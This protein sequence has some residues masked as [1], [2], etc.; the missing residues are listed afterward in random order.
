MITFPSLKP[1]TAWKSLR[2]SLSATL[3]LSPLLVTSGIL[4]LGVSTASAASSFIADYTTFTLGGLATQ[5][6]WAQVTS[7]TNTVNPI[8]VIAAVSP[9]PQSIKVKGV[10][11]A[12]LAYRDLPTAFNP[13]GATST[14]TFYYVIENF[15]VL[16]AL[17]SSTGTGSGVCALTTT[18]GGTGTYLSRLYVRR[19]QGSSAN[20]ATFDL[21]MN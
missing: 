12:A 10:A 21:G 8:Q 4:A 14:A 1:A 19:F 11:S 9:V 3:R 7:A 13:V 6:S 20:T 18:L 15:R 5:N 2:N 16:Q 17:N